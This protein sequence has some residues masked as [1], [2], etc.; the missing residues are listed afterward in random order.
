MIV[1]TKMIVG[2]Y[3]QKESRIDRHGESE[4]GEGD[5]YQ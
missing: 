2:R 1:M 4:I 5:N 3:V